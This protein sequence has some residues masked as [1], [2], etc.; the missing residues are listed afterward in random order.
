MIFS[1][2]SII[3]LFSLYYS[4]VV[5]VESYIHRPPAIFRTKT[6]ATSSKRSDNEL[7]SNE[8]VKI[9]SIQSGNPS[10]LVSSPSDGQV[11]VCTNSWCR[12][13]GSDGVLAAFT[14]LTPENTQVVG[15]NCL[16]RCNKGP[17]IRILSKQGKF[18]EETSVRSIET[19]VELLQKHL[20]LAV[21]YT[22]AEVLKLNY[23]GNIYLRNGDVDNAISCYD[24]ALELGDKE[25]E[26]VLL[27]MR[28]TA[29]LQRAY[30]S[31]LKY[32]D[33]LAISQE[34][35]PTKDSIIL[36]FNALHFLHPSLRLRLF[37]EILA[38]ISL[39]F[40]SFDY[41]SKLNEYKIKW[42]ELKGSNP[43]T[44]GEVSSL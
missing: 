7:N 12:E 4:T 26:G 38:K 40:K 27:V 34:F 1:L 31:K 37:S 17:N 6:Y 39:I 24:R 10:N 14:F 3:F 2:I 5:F 32:K 16:G 43:L 15:V 11:F 44:S 8:K 18:I 36:I 33:I 30:A 29:L 19:V 22:S 42:N 41:S 35:I 25:Q 21:N 23:E 13:R 20:S 9:S 28:G